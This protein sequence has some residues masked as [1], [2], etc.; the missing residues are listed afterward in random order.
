MSGESRV[1]TGYTPRPLQAKL[2]R[3]LRRFNVLVMHRRFGKTV[4][5]VNEKLDRALNNPLVR[6]QYAYLA[7]TYGQAKRVAW[8]YF[9]QFTA[10]IPGATPNEAELRIDIPRPWLGD[11]IRLML[12]GAENPMSLKGMYLDGVTLDEVAEMNPSVWGEVIRPTL[13]DRKGWANFI[14][15]PKGQNHFYD[16]REYAKSGDPEWFTAL[17]KASET[18]IIDKDELDSARRSMTEEEYNQEY[19]C[20]F[21]SGLAGAYFAKELSRAENEKRI[22]TIP[23]DPALLVDTYWDLGINDTCAVWFVQSLRGRHRLIDYYEVCGASI[24]EVLREVRRKPYDFGE[25]VLPHDAKA[26]SFQTGKSQ[27]ETFY[28][29]GVKRYRIIPRIGT[30]RESINAARMIFS[31]CEFDSERCAKGLKALANYQ[32][33]WNSKNNVF[34]EAPLHNWA[35]NCADA[36]QQFAMGVREDSRDSLGGQHYN[37]VSSIEAETEYNVFEGLP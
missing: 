24:A 12:L 37:G 22:T 15:T 13:S 11:H 34:E 19:E 17:Y 27:E 8:D 23:H 3:S 35:S 7:P 4:F 2:H 28:N 36:F 10:K 20:D 1:V 6:P 26:R 25:F 18:G 31:Q 5:A 16:L 30:K 29:L 9:K 21:N 32:R 33:K 14:G